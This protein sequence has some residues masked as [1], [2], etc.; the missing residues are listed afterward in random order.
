MGEKE[1]MKDKDALKSGIWTL[2]A[3]VV[4]TLTGAYAGAAV[5]VLLYLSVIWF[6]SYVCFRLTLKRTL[7]ILCVSPVSWIIYVYA[8]QFLFA[9]ISYHVSY[10]RAA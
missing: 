7:L 9:I 4:S 2:P 5:T 6:I 1:V 8:A 10:T 3:G